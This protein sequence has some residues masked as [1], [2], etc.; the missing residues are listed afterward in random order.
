MRPRAD[1]D[2]VILKAWDRPGTVQAL[3]KALDVS[4]WTVRAHARALGLPPDGPRRAREARILEL[5]RHGFDTRTISRAVGVRGWCV[6]W[7][8]RRA[9]QEVSHV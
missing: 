9:G 5:H 6:R 3:A 7:H 1:I 4:V 2:G 8:V